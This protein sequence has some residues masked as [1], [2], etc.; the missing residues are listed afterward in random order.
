[1]ATKNRKTTPRKASAKSARKESGPKPGKKREEAR[2]KKAAAKPAPKKSAAGSGSKRPVPKVRTTPK[3]I[4][5]KA[6]L[7]KSAPPAKVA[8][9]TEPGKKP[10]QSKAILSAA[11]LAAGR[12]SSLRETEARRLAKKKEEAKRLDSKKTEKKKAV[13]VKPV[14]ESLQP[15]G[16]YNGVVV[17]HEV[18]PFP[19]K[20]PYSKAELDKLREVLLEERARLLSQLASLSGV[21]MEAM[22]GAK[23][24][25]GYS[26]HIAEH[27]SD[28]QAAE[29]NIGVRSIEEDR[30]E[31]V[32]QALDRLKH[33][34][35]HYGLCLACGSK[36]GI[37]RL[38]AR[39]HAHL[40]MPCRKRFEA[41]RSHR[42]Y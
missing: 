15:T 41:I 4:A 23:E 27:A 33:N 18:K 42:G 30:L 17:A 36:I 12:K 21:S 2:K 29:A 3:L 24:N 37:Q 31:Q 13:V 19:V 11:K 25:A 28:L 39:P 20:T 16:I 38:I 26:I 35:N 1:M 6:P 32:E 22:G 8:V 7:K 34:L 10:V 9:R 14:V 40:C 5:P